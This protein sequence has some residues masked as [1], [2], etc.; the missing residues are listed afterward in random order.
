MWK[1]KIKQLFVNL[2]KFLPVAVAI[3]SV[4]T[5]VSPNPSQQDTLKLAHDI[6]DILAI[7]FLN[8]SPCK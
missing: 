8:N 2:C 5:A 3:A 7:H 4:V 1:H 6:L